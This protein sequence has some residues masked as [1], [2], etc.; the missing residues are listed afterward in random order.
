MAK[1]QTT[2]EVI[3]KLI[4]QLKRFKEH[5]WSTPNTYNSNFERIPPEP[6]IYFL[7]AYKHVGPYRAKSG[8][9]M[10]APK[11]KIVYIGSSGNLKNRHVAHNI[12]PFVKRDFEYVRTYFKVIDRPDLYEI[13][14]ALIKAIRPL[15]NLQHTR[16]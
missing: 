4:K 10:P 16:G 11:G 2:T 15:Y 3:S 14:V 9:I 7:F 1:E 6:G 5:M 8:R 13:E 12:M